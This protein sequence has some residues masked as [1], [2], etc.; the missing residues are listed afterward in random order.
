M[1]IGTLHFV[2]DMELVI[3]GNRLLRY[4][5]AERKSRDEQYG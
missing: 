3:E 2:V 1:T 5:C 4:G